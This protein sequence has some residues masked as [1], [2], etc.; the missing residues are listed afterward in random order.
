[1]T[2]PKEPSGLKYVLDCLA[3]S[4]DNSECWPVYPAES[5]IL[6]G[7]IN[8][9]RKELEELRGER[10]AVVAWLRERH[11][12][13]QEWDGR[14]NAVSHTYEHAANIIERGE[15]RSEGEK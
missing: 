9:L 8:R 10:A 12:A 1:M 13:T 6:I 4:A 3:R 5:G 11:T 7:E 14:V 2:E 15:H